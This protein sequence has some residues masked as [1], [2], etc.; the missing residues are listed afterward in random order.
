[1][2]DPIAFLYIE[3]ANKRAN[4][5]IYEDILYWRKLSQT[6]YCIVI[7]ALTHVVPAGLGDNTERGTLTGW[8]HDV[9]DFEAAMCLLQDLRHCVTSENFT[10]AQFDVTGKLLIK[11]PQKV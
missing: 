11:G 3:T 4:E 7:E 8:L 6:G 2:N 1:M 10:V 5:E 9:I